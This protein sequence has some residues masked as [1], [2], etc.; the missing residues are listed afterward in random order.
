M[1]REVAQKQLTNMLLKSKDYIAL[2][3]Q[4]PDLAD[5]RLVLPDPDDQ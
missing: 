1:L 4:F 2:C 3:K 5:H